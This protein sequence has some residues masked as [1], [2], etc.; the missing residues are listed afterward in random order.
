METPEFTNSA[1]KHQVN[2]DSIIHVMKNYPPCPGTA[3]NS[4]D[5]TLEY[6]G[7]GLDGIAIHI[8]VLARTPRVVIHAQPCYQYLP[9]S[10]RNKRRKR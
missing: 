6:A 2:Q 4:N 5:P 7:L 10:K 3:N 1:S 8:T 9:R